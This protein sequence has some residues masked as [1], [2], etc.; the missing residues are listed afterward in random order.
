MDNQSLSLEELTRAVGGKLDVTEGGSSNEA[1]VTGAAPI[2]SA[3]PGDV[4]FVA[5]ARNLKSLASTRA[6]AVI[7]RERDLFEETDRGGTTLI[8]VDNPHLAMAKV[9]E[10]IRPTVHPEPGVAAG[11]RLHETAVIGK[12]VS[13]GVGA[14]I[15]EDAQI[16]DRAVIYPGVYIGRNVEIG[17]ESVIY[18]NVTVM[19]RCT[20]GARVII[21]SGT[22]IGSDGFGYAKE[23][24]QYYKI[25]QT[26]TVRI[27]DDVEIGACVTVD[28][29]M[30][31]E[32]VIGRGTKI[33]NLVQVA[34]NVVVGEDTVIVA[35]VGIAGSSAVGSRV[36]LGG[37]VGIVGHVRVGDDILIGAR[38]VVTNNLT[39]PGAY[40]GFPAINHGDWLRAQTISQKLPELRKKVRELE[41]KI[42]ELEK[43]LDQ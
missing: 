34:H 11:A 33:D 5:D 9:L 22:V 28:R 8:Y 30:L 16:G 38:G 23:A 14:V 20:L 18:P 4:S 26:G 35:Q 25:P 43:S 24:E 19:E 7:L 1:V 17:E 3:G 40:S 29:A 36:Q 37:Q 10:A 27:A 12:K 13:I 39:R 41:R 15:E 21:H 31:G 6:T 32:T 2:D 42:I